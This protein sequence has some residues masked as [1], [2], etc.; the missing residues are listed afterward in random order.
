MKTVTFIILFIV[1]SFLPS[2][3]V[4]GQN[5]NTSTDSVINLII[6]SWNY[7]SHCGYGYGGKYMCSYKADNYNPSTKYYIFSKVN[8]TTDSIAYEYYEKYKLKQTGRARVSYSNTIFGNRWNINSIP[9][10]NQTIGVIE[11]PVN[12]TLSLSRDACFDCY[13]DKLVRRVE[14]SAT[15]VTKYDSIQND[16]TL[17]ID[18]ATASTAASYMWNFGDGATSFLA[19]P[20]HTYTIDGVYDVCLTVTTAAADNCTYCRKIGK[21]SLGNIKRSGG[22]SLTVVNPYIYSTEVIKRNG[23][24]NQEYTIRPNPNDGNMTLTYT[25]ND[26][27]QL[28][29][30]DIMGRIMDEYELD[31]GKNL[32]YI[33]NEHLVN[34]TYFYRVVINGSNVKTGKIVVVR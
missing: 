4:Y 8:G 9:T 14:C 15:Y 10:P 20:S 24:K 26:K 13:G 19:T 5:Q 21:D 22:F 31:A 6:G 32:F 17:I 7:Y 2:N 18:S 28:I 29:L 12:D 34:G 11:F 3:K 25:I 30:Y 16:F 23:Q 33:S 27:A 1:S